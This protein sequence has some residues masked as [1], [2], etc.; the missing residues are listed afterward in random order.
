MPLDI[1]IYCEDA[2]PVFFNLLDFSIAPPFLYYSYIPLI[3]ALLIFSGFMLFSDRF[4]RNT[5]LL[6]ALSLSLC[7]AIGATL[8]QWIAAPVELVLYSWQVWNLFNVGIFLFTAYFAYSFI[9]QKDLP[10]SLKIVFVTLALPVVLFTGT[11]L[12]ISAFDYAYCEGVI[13]PLFSYAYLVD[14]LCIGFI[15]YITY[16]AYKN[17]RTKQTKQESLVVGVNS[18]VLLILFLSTTVLADHTGNYSIEM[19]GSFGGVIFLA[20]M[21]YLVVRFKEFNTKII[22]TEL[23]VAALIL[24]VGSIVF[25]QT[26]ESV[27]YVATGSV[28]LTLFLGWMLIKSVRREVKQRIEI[29]RLAGHLEEAN[30]RLKELDKM[31][32]EFVSIASHQLRSPLTAIRGYVSMLQ[33]G[34]YG[35]ITK[36][37]IEPLERIETSAKN[38]AYSVEDYLNVSRIESGNMKYNYTDFNLRDEV[39]HVC[40]DLRPQALRKGL[41]LIFRTNL[42]SQ[43]IINADIGKTIQIVQNLINNSIKYTQKGSVRV[44]VRD[45]VVGKKIYVDIED[46]GVGM[47]NDTQA[48]LFQKF[49]RAKNASE[50]NTGGTGLGLFVAYKMAEAMGGDIKAKSEGDGKGSLFTIEFPMAL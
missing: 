40:D 34:S 42:M 8:L 47:N 25:V 32:S 33:E 44:L 18:L 26:I 41:T 15:G 22:A 38:M 11:Q 20:G 23:L 21:G 28:L 16:D 30:G 43:G 10:P 50:I 5:R 36:K 6:T 48:R 35:R 39:E 7:G 1:P 4:S 17:F 14:V 24:T 13:G 12:N 2:N 9:Y 46:T 45:D 3:I 49:E 19:L 29:E 27:R 31:K 37:M